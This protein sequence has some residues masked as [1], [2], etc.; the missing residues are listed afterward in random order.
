MPPSSDLSLILQQFALLMTTDLG[1]HGQRAGFNSLHN[2]RR[3]LSNTFVCYWNGIQKTL[4]LWGRAIV[5]IGLWF[6]SYNQIAQCVQPKL[7]TTDQQ[8]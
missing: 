3:D 4:L 7:Q 1:V 2:A 6:S 5:Y 8:L